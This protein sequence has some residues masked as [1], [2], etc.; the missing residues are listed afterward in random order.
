MS[1]GKGC[2]LL[3]ILRP[4]LDKQTNCTLEIMDPETGAVRL[5]PNEKVS[6]IKNIRKLLESIKSDINHNSTNKE[7]YSYWIEKGW[8]KSIDYYLDSRSDNFGADTRDFLIKNQQIKFKNFISNAGLTTSIKPLISISQALIRRRTKRLF[9]K[10]Q[11]KNEIF[12]SGLNHSI[13]N[14]FN[15]TNGFQFYFIIYNV[16]N[17]VP[18]VYSYDT[19]SNALL[20][21]REGLF[22]NDMSKNIQGMRATK[23]AAFS[24]IIV[25]N[26]I[27]LMKEIPYKRGLRDVYIESGILAQK[28]IIAYMQYEI[29][30]LATP[31]L[32]DRD[33][34]NLLKL[35]EPDFSPVYSLTFGYPVK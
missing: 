31:A 32:R 15:I 34:L 20:L 13:A 19:K 10:E 5:I 9:N 24:M 30:S 3:T 29:F 25:A 23:T 11:V 16:E 14:L 27:S 26:F 18:G 6:N 17:I 8:S 2:S 33:V 12:Y 1:E 28:F 4:H 21:V 22:S 35:N 7:H